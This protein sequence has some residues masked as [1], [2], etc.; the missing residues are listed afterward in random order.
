MKKL[1]SFDWDC[2]SMGSIDGLFIATQE[3][4]DA[5][6]GKEIYFGEVLGKYSE[7]YGTIEPDEIKVRITDQ[8]VIVALLIVFGNTLCGYN[9]LDYL[10]E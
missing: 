1:F 6:V 2:G 4:V 3:E 9:P 5:L 7:I 8:N 10:E